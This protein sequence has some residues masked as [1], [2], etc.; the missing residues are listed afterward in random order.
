MADTTTTNLLLTKPEVGAS[1]DTWGNKVNTDLD[2]VDSVFAAAGTGTSVGLNVG[3]GKTLAV[4]GTAVISGTLTAA[5]GS[6]AAPTIT[7]TGD[8]NTGIFFPAADTIAFS[9]GGAEAMRINSSGNVLFGTGSA[10]TT[11]GGTTA[12]AGGLTDKDLTVSAWFPTSGANEYGGDLY[13]SAGRPTG[14]GSGK[15]GSIYLKV[16]V[17]GSP[18]SAAGSL[19]TAMTANNFGIGIGSAVPSSGFGVAFPA[20]QSAS[21]NA[22][23]L[24]D[25]EEGT[26]TPSLGG[27]ATYNVQTGAYTKIGNVVSIT[28]SIRT[29]SLGTGSTN[30]LTGLPFTAAADVFCGIP[31]GDGFAVSVYSVHLLIYGT[32][33]EVRGFTA[34]STSTQVVNLFATGTRIYFSATYQV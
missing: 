3:A 2:L 23:T 27:T 26:W 4:A 1:T 30:T 15:L 20:T 8:T 7:A 29:T 18:S 9:E 21:S 17:S 19:I 31:F 14:N 22:N 11:I 12:T 13:L 34:A 24:D 32:S 5:A 25:Y 33:L 6:A 28:G 16:G 10:A